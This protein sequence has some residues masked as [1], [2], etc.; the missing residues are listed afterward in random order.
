MDTY[1]TH[2]WRPEMLP[3][4]AHHCHSFGDLNFY[5]RHDGKG[6]HIMV[7]DDFIVTGIINWEFATTES[8]AHTFSSPSMMWDLQKFCNRSSELTTEQV[9][10]AEISVARE[11][12]TLP[13]SSGKVGRCS[14]FCSFWPVHLTPSKTSRDCSKV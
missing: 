10:F 3:Q 11:I 8:K 5:S 14:D 13:K 12:A 6:D 9:E 4:V 7:D 1:L 2:Y